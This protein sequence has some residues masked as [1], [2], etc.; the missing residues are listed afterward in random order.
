MDDKMLAKYYDRLTGDERFRLSL[1]ANARDDTRELV[2]G[3]FES[4]E[5]GFDLLGTRGVTYNVR[6]SLPCPYP[7]RSFHEVARAAPL[8]QALAEPIH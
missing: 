7:R 1:E 8:H 4:D 5:A 6:R 2:V 3:Q